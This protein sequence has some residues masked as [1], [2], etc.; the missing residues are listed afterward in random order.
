MAQLTRSVPYSI[1]AI[2]RYPLHVAHMYDR[3]HLAQTAAVSG[4]AQRCDWDSGNSGKIAESV[5]ILVHYS[6]AHRRDLYRLQ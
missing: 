4:R 1:G 3:K 5:R 2:M 6:R